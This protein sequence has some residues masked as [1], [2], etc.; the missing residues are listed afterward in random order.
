M[1]SLLQEDMGWQRVATSPLRRCSEFADEVATS[2]RLPI[3][4]VEDLK[5]V[6]F[7]NWEGQSPEQIQSQDPQAYQAFYDDPVANRPQ[8]AEPLEA[9]FRRT[10]DAY[11]T[12]L[13]QHPGEHLVFIVH[14]GV[15][16]AIVTAAL[17]APIASMYKLRVDYAS[18]SRIRYN[19]GLAR[20]E[21]FN[22]DNYRKVK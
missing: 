21:C 15:I 2:Y 4:I 10:N 12:V 19:S 14:A 20:L 16:R 22:N 3:Q 1:R 5:E 8:G 6:G 17:Q 11:K 7:G 18:L 13:E 9:F